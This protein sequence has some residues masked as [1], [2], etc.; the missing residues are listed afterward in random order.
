MNQQ[1]L[2]P[3]HAYR[4]P[5]FSPVGRRVGRWRVFQQILDA[6]L[7]QRRQQF[8]EKKQSAERRGEATK[9]KAVPHGHYMDN[10]TLMV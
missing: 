9:G 5:E 6:V 1:T 4:I 3:Y 7:T 8:L 2:Y 10:T